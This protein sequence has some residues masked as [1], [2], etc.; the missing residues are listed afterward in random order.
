MFLTELLKV[1]KCQAEPDSSVVLLVE[2]GIEPWCDVSLV[3][4]RTVWEMI[5]NRYKAIEPDAE[6][7]MTSIMKRDDKDFMKSFAEFAM[8][9]D[10]YVTKRSELVGGN[11]VELSSDSEPSEGDTNVEDSVGSV[12]ITSSE[13]KGAVAKEMEEAKVPIGSIELNTA[14]IKSEAKGNI[15]SIELD[16]GSNKSTEN[17]ARGTN[18][19]FDSDSKDKPEEVSEE[20]KDNSEPV[21]VA[22][23]SAEEGEDVTALSNDVFGDDREAD[24]MNPSM[25]GDM[26]DSVENSDLNDFSTSDNL[27]GYAY[28]DTYSS[29]A[30]PE[31]NDESDIPEDEDFNPFASNASS[32]S[33]VSSG[34][35]QPFDLDSYEDEMYMGK[36]SSSVSPLSPIEELG[37]VGVSDSGGSDEF[38]DGVSGVSKLGPSDEDTSSDFGS[39]IEV[40][41]PVMDEEDS[42]EDEEDTTP[43]VEEDVDT[44]E[45]SEDTSESSSGDVVEDS[46]EDS[47]EDNEEDSGYF[48]NIAEV[49]Q[50]LD[51]V[52][53]GEEESSESDEEEKEDERD[54]EDM[55]KNLV[56]KQVEE[57]SAQEKRSREELLDYLSHRLHTEETI[58]ECDVEWAS[59]CVKMYSDMMHD[60]S[61]ILAENSLSSLFESIDMTAQDF[62]ENVLDAAY[63]VSKIHRA[64]PSIS[65]KED[66]LLLLRLAC[67]QSLIYCSYGFE[68][69]AVAM[70]LLFSDIIYEE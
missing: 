56:G 47:E 23:Q 35:R 44:S 60:Y 57:F 54:V 70:A 27:S 3:V 63:Q 11:N 13:D 28:S 53:Q 6:V 36:S 49:I 19:E 41:E 15:G 10:T 48:T 18:I 21:E 50:S 24:G 40:P 22:E 7:I 52:P 1:S 14:P 34:P 62:Y 46:E 32:S 64:C 16:I 2:S 39:L 51:N 68:D 30:G 67:E 37:S 17:V 4:P 20:V 29:D 42:G 33:G 25:S 61:E 43:D 9:R 12:D 38:D 5:Y 26:N 55:N 8:V 31:M 65:S 45:S 66:F 58:P 69:E 59:E